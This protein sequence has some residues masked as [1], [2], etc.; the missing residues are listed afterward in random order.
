MLSVI[1]FEDEEEVIKM[2]N[3]N[4]YGLASSVWTQDINKALRVAKGLRAGMVAVNSNG[5]PG[6]FGPFGGYK[7]SGIGRETHKMAL[8]HYQQ[9]K[10]LLVSYDINPMGFF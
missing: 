2:A 9:T 8:E 4:D 7:K 6:V 5:G 10:N 1:P 3:S